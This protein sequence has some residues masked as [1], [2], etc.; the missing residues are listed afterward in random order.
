MCRMPEIDLL[1]L[2]TETVT[3][4]LETMFFTAP[5]DLAE[6]VCGE[7]G[8]EA[9]VAFHGAPSGIFHLRISASGARLI[10]AAFLG[11]VEDSLGQAETEQVVCEL[12]NMVCGSMVSRLESDRSFDLAVPELVPAG[13]LGSCLV[14]VAAR[15]SFE[16]ECGTL[17]LVLHL[18]AA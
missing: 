15:Q 12:A 11:K 9:R 18:E 2:T 14:P 17:T 5:L 16:L 10:A 8:I 4:V 3:S 6:E 7:N 13:A 1:E